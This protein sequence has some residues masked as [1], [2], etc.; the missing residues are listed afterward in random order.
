VSACRIPNTTKNMPTAERT[1]PK[2]S[3]G[4][5]G[6]GGMGSSTRRL[7]RTIST[8]TPTWKMNA[9]R[10]LIAVVTM[11]P[12]SGP[13]AAP[14]PPSPLI[15]PKARAREVRSSNLSVVRM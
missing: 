6:S 10:Q 15:T 13:A 8:M 4:R 5:V 12:I 7:S 11:P 2:A 14:M 1:A 3:K 9:A